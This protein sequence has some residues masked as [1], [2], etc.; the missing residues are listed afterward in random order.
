M[1]GSCYSQ[2][3]CGIVLLNFA[4]LFAIIGLCLDPWVLTPL[5]RQKLYDQLAILPEHEN[6]ET[7]SAWKS[8]SD[9]K[10]HP[11]ELMSFHVSR[12]GFPS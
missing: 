11:E 4:F 9:P 12:N 2:N 1:A 3:C 10:M 7:Y 8:N 6:A 5:M